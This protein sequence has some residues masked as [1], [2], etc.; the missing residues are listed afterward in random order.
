MIRTNVSYTPELSL[1]HRG[2]EFFFIR[3][4]R[5]SA[6]LTEIA[7]ARLTGSPDA[8][9]ELFDAYGA[10]SPVTARGGKIAE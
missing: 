1:I 7:A 6:G 8:L 9:A 5:N 3:A 2:N 10:G 4:P